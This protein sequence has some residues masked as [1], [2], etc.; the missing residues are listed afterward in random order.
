MRWLTGGHVLEP[1]GSRFVKADIGVD[2][3]RIARIVLSAS[4]A[5][6]DDVVE[7]D[8]RWLLPGLIDCHVT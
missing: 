8:G 7:L 1:E 4:P 6:G 2:D 3:D 5:A